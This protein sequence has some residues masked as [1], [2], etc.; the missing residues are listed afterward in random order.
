[1]QGNLEA[2]VSATTMPLPQVLVMQLA[3]GGVPA[4]TR[5][6]TVAADGASMTE[7]VAYFGPDGQPALRKNVFMRIR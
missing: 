2:D 1:M 6:Y 4:S 7:T 5:I 3:K